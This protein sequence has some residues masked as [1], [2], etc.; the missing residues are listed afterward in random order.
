MLTRKYTAIGAVVFALCPQLV[1]ASNFQ[2]FSGID[3]NNPA[4]LTF[5]VQDTQIIL[6]FE[7]FP[8]APHVT[9]KGSV[10]VPDP[11]GMGNNVV[12]TGTA[13]NIGNSSFPYGRIAKRLSKQW[14]A[15]L[16]VT[17]PFKSDII[18]P[19]DSIVRYVV[20]DSIIHSVD[21]APSVAY[22]FG[23]GLS[24]LAV[25]FGLDAM[26][27]KIALNSKYP[28]F[29]IPPNIPF[30][31]GP[32]AI[33]TNGASSWNYGW[34]AGAIYH[35]SK[36]TILAASYF[37]AIKQKFSH[38]ESTFTGFPDSHDFATSLNLPATSNF[39][40]TQFI[41]EKM[42]VFAQA[43]Y[44][45]WHRLQQTIL[46]N[47]AGPAS[48]IVL[49]FH[50]RNT[51]RYGLAGRYSLTPDLSLGGIICYDSTPTNNADRNLALPG[52][53]LFILGGSAE[54]KLTKE[55]A[56]QLEYG[57]AFTINVPLNNVEEGSGITTVGNA[58]IYG[59]IFGVQLS[60]NI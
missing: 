46:Y 44:S 29:P 32:D 2:F 28:S 18:Y 11:T 4:D 13:K 55:L 31:A 60:F 20:T 47:T 49:N 12:T 23:G 10:M 34:H 14:V 40:L 51:W 37:S 45:Q 57:H 36:S 22:Q 3:Y 27:M 58:S 15:S 19:G 9:F 48:E 39:S 8:P 5:L 41:G 33:F 42:I 30:G 1:L 38:G 24:N 52:A 59:N 26:Y 43:S 6:G 53:N 7:Y 25:G 35:V 50:Y 56:L 21:V 54:Y 17:E 16:D